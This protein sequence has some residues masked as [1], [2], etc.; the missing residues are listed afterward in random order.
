MNIYYEG[1]L[2]MDYPDLLKKVEFPK[3]VPKPKY[4]KN[5]EE[6]QI[7]NQLINER[8]G[9]QKTSLIKS[10]LADKLLKFEEIDRLDD[11][12]LQGLFDD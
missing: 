12:L 2:I 9:N 6:S 1:E 3:D 8:I 11:E 10:T 7:R 5:E 4:N